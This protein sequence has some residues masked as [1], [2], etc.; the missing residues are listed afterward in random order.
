MGAA[1]MM[2][3]PITTRGNKPESKGSKKPTFAVGPGQKEAY[4]RAVAKRRAWQIAYAECWTRW[5][6]GDRTVIWPANTWKMRVVHRQPCAP[7]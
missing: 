4:R 7:P 5:Q 2:S 1:A 6:A 3:A